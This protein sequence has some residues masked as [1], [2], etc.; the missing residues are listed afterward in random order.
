MEKV[1]F[2]MAGE[3]SLIVE[4]Q[5]AVAYGVESALASKGFAV[6]WVATG[7]KALDFVHSENPHIS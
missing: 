3:R 2:D 6:L 7:Q 5:C 4:D 1:V